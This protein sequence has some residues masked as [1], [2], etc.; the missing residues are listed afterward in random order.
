MC[1]V[2]IIDDNS[3]TRRLTRAWLQRLGASVD[4]VSDGATALAR[5]GLLVPAVASTLTDMSVLPEVI[6]LDMV[7]PDTDGWAVLRAIRADARLDGVAVY[8]YSG[9]VGAGAELNGF[10]GTI[11]K[12][13]SYE[14]FR[15]GFSSLTT[16]NQGSRFGARCRKP[17]YGDAQI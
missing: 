15:D 12:S 7:L 14:R 5:L 3:L 4:E 13:G 11:A 8:C 9:T 2:L 10:D 16:R 17:I 1:R 6:L